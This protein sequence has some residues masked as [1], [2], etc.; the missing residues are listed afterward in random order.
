M[1]DNVLISFLR[2]RR[3]APFKTPQLKTLSSQV[4]RLL[5][6]GYY[7]LTAMIK[8]DF[9]HKGVG[10]LNSMMYNKKVIHWLYIKVI[11]NIYYIV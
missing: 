4:Q 8:Y 6:R 5:F 1:K 2:D 11:H 3:T 10:G 7:Y 9:V